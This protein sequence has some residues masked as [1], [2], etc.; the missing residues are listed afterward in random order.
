[1]AARNIK[2]HF[3]SLD[4]VFGIVCQLE[5]LTKERLVEVARRVGVE[6]RGRESRADLIRAILHPQPTSPERETPAPI[7][8]GPRP[9]RG[10]HR[11][12]TTV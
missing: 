5:S 1:M 3:A 10:A 7:S 4:T 6:V 9:R 8:N 12:P 11:G 2:R